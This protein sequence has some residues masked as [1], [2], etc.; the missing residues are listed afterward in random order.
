M[1]IDR[2]PGPG[3][4]ETWT[5]SDGADEVRVVPERGGIV[6]HWAVC[7]EHLLF[8]DEATLIDRSKNVRG[9]IPLLFPNAGPL[10]PTGADFGGRHI[11]QLQHGLARLASWAVLHA[12]ADDDTARLELGLTSSPATKAGFPFDFDAHLAV[13]LSQG[14]LTLE[15]LFTNTGVEAMPLHA[16]LHP[17]FT[18]PLAQK[19]KAKVPTQATV[20]KERR[21]GALCPVTEFRFD[22][23]ELDVA[24]LE[25]G[26]AASLRRGDGSRIELASTPELSTLVLWTLPNQPF[27]CVEPWTAPGGALASGEGLLILPPSSTRRL[28]VQLRFE[29]A[30][31]ANG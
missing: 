27:I 5:L 30:G 31:R 9:G 20:F 26:P 18:V 22:E 11:T 24:V 13:S 12:I 8:L 23:G 28:A 7:G 10:P 29:P 3:D 1:R 17:Y 21:S 2:S 19:S 4:L 16:G 25:H 15:W 6:T 14:Q